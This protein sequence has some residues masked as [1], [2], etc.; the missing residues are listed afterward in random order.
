MQIQN[1]IKKRENI[2]FKYNF[3]DGNREKNDIGFC[4]IC[5]DEQI[6]KHMKTHADNWC[7]NL[8]C[9]CYQ[10]YNKKITREDLG[11]IFPCVE[12]ILLKNWTAYAGYFKSNKPKT[13]RSCNLDALCIITSRNTYEKEDKRFIFA[14]FLVDEL[15]EGN[16]KS[17]G[18]V[19]CNSKYKIK[20]T[21]DEAK[22]M[23]FWK[24][25]YCP[26]SPKT[27]KWG[28]TFR[29]LDYLQAAYILR[30][31][32]RIKKGSKDQNLADDFYK[33]FCKIHHIDVVGEP[34]GALVKHNR[35]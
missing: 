27:I 9:P 8:E 19:L 31:I 26:K 14:V 28:S 21:Y 3:C 22:K 7:C 32:A 17:Q 1:K 10:Y 16:N 13:I 35:F 25:Y 4:G 12:S 23:P 6:E 2:A 29:Y 34:N 5:S 18:T 20:L 15:F 33:Y 24:Y 11:D 30:D